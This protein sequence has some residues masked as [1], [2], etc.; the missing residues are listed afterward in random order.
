MAKNKLNLANS[1]VRKGKTL[2][3]FLIFTQILL[4]FTVI[5]PAQAAFPK[6]INFQGKLTKVSDGTNVATAAYAMEFKI[7]DALT[8]GTLLWTETYDQPSGNC[9]KPTITNGVFN[10]K[11]GTCNALTIDVTTGSLYVSVNFAPTGTSYD[12]EMS[13]RKQLVASAFAFNANNLVG[14]GRADLSY[15]PSNSTNPG[16]QINYA[17]GVSSANNALSVIASV[18]VTGPAVNISQAGSGV[19]L[20][21]A[22]AGSNARTINSTS[23]ALVL[24]TTTSGNITLNPQTG[25]VA[26]QGALS[27]TSGGATAM[28]VDAGGA[29]GLNLGT[30]SANALSIS[31]TGIA[32]TIQGTATFNEVATI[33]NGA[34]NDYLGFVAEGTNPSCSS[35]QYRIWAN[36]S[37]TKLKKCENGT[38]TDL[39]TTTGGSQTPWTTDIDAD[40]FSLLDFGPN[41]TSRATL[42]IASS[43]NGSGASSSVTATT[44]TGTS[45]SGNAVLNTGNASAGTAGN[46]VFDVGTSTASNG[47]ILIGT[48][49]RAQTV[50]IGNS[51]G[52]ATRLGQNG[53]TVQ[54]DGTNFDVDTNGTVTVA[55][56]QSY[57]GA[58]AVTLSSGASA[59]LTI[60]SASGRTTFATGDFLKTSVAGVSGAASG[61]IWYDSTANKYKINE[62]G[63]TKI[64]CNATDAGCG[65]GG[66]STLQTD[67][68]NDVDGS[69]VVIALTTA[70][71]S[72]IFQNP[73][74][75]GTDSAFTV[76]IDQL[77]TGAVDGL[78][79]SNAGTGS[80]LF[81]NATS[82]GALAALQKN[83]T[84]VFTVANNG[85]L[86]INGITTDVVKT[87]TGSTNSSDFSISGSTLTNITSQNDTITIND[88]SVPSSGNG[89]FA[90]STVVTTAAAGAGSHT[91]L[92]EDGQVIVVHGNSLATCSRW[93]GMTAT[94]TSV[95]CATGATNPGVGAISL[96]RPDGRYLLIH[97][98]TT[99]LSTLFDPWGV[100][101]NAAGPTANFC[102][103]AAEGTNAF[104]RDDGKY[105]VLCGG[106]TAW[107]VYD[108]TAN[109][110]VAGTAV[111]TAFG[112]GAFAIHRDDGTFLVFAGGN[113]T[114]HWIY[115]PYASAT[116]T[117][118]LNSI[119]SNA[120][121]ITTGAFA[122]RRQDGK[123]L[124]LGGAINTS[125]V[126]DPTP[127]NGTNSGAGSMTSQ[128]G[129]GFGPTA[130]LA[131]GAQAV[132]REDWKYTLIA[133][134]G[135][136]VTN[137]IDP[138]KSDSTQ[139]T[140]GANIT[141]AGAGVHMFFQPDGKF[142]VIRG[143][144]TT[145]TDTYDIGYI[146]G[147]A[148][149]GVALTAGAP[150]AGGSMTNGTHSY[151]VTFLTS[152][153][154]SGLGPVSNQINSASTNQTSALSA[155]PIGPAGT[156]GRRVYRTVAGDTGNYLLL[157]TISDN[158]TTTFSDTLAD[159]SLGTAAPT[160]T[161][162][163]YETEC[164]TAASLNAN[165]T[166]SWNTNSEGKFSFQ[167]R[168]GTA[169]ALSSTYKDIV[170]SG[171]PIRPT[172]GDT[173]IQIKV[174]FQRQIPLFADQEWGIRRGKGQT[175][176]RRINQDPSLFD[177]SVDN[178]NL[179]RKT[180]FDFGLGGGSGA[181]ATDPSGPLVV[182][183]TNNSDRNLSLTLPTGIGWG[184]TVNAT[185]PSLYNG[186]WST[187]P[188]AL[189][190]APVAAGSDLVMRRPD[191]RF[192]IV[193]SNAAANAQLYDP[194][195]QTVTA[196]SGGSNVPTAVIGTGA[197][198]FKRP[199]GKFFIVHGNASTTTNI[200][201]PVASTFAAGPATTAAV[202]IGAQ[203]IPLP[204]G[205]VLILHGN[206]TTASSIYDPVQN[207]MYS[208]PVTSAAVT[209]GSIVI[210]RPDGKWVVA[211]GQ[212]GTAPGT[213]PGALL[214]VSNTFDP[215]TMTFTATGSPAITGGPG[216]FAFQRS[217]GLWAI[218]RGGATITTCA[219]VTTT[220]IYNPFTNKVAAGPA[221]SAAAQMGAH[222]IP[223]P[224][225]TWLIVHGSATSATTT[226]IY[227]EKAG[228][229]T[230]E[231]GGSVGQFVA[232][233]ALVT[234]AGAGAV[235][236]QRPDGK[237][238][239][240]VGNATTTLN[241]YDAGWMTT[242]TY[243]S[244]EVTISDLDSSSTLVWKSN[245]GT[246]NISAEART[247][248]SQLGL[249]T[250]AWREIGVSGG[251]INPGA[252]ETWVQ[253][254]FNFKRTFPSYGGLQ[255]DVWYTGGGSASMYF[256]QRPVAV[257]TLYEYKVTKDIN[258]VNLQADGLSMFRVSSS[259]DIFTSSTGTVNT[260]GADLAER[261]TSSTL[262]EPGSVVAIDPENNHGVRLSSYQYQYDVLGIV[263][264]A[265]GFVA[266][267]YT[268]DSYPIA[269]IGRVPVKVTTENGPIRTGD[270]I[271]ASSLTGYAMK[272][273]QAGRVLGKVLESVDNAKL[274]DC[275]ASSMNIERQCATVMVFVNLIDYTGSSVEV[276]LSDFEQAQVS[277]VVE[278]NV[279]GLAVG[280][281]ISA[282]GSVQTVA[283]K[284]A[285]I[286]EFLQVLRQQKTASALNFSEV[287]TDRVSAAFEVITPAV[288]TQGLNV[289]NIT[290]IK[291]AITFQSDSIFFGRPYFNIDTA[292]FALVKKGQK[293]V[294]IVFDK[295]YVEQPVVSV[296]ISL[297]ESAE[298]TKDATPEKLVEIQTAEGALTDKLFASGIQF[299]VTRKNVHGFTIL[300]NKPL[301]E[302]LTFSWI[303]LAVK[304][305]RIFGADVPSINV[306]PTPHLG[307]VAGATDPGVA[308]RNASDGAT[309]NQNASESAPTELASPISDTPLPNEVS[310]I[311][312][313]NE[314]SQVQPPPPVPEFATP[315]PS[316]ETAS[317]N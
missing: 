30:S 251:L 197:L 124:V 287:F 151:K 165:S 57:A 101:A 236:F 131:D 246:Q 104:L 267:G 105:V 15:A 80:G 306:T 257:P 277:A 273:T 20:E 41:L 78:R 91:I 84:S 299:F 295:E 120:P 116:G 278:V 155:I 54:I 97:G 218:V 304:N 285:R 152:A 207:V 212:T 313:S 270:Y 314:A 49:S 288:Y 65:A 166:L 25:I 141:G 209:F 309:L 298:V 292:G 260:G 183:L 186:A 276:A 312:Q 290:S 4:A 51:T 64:L 185:N 150:T 252:S 148:L 125:S 8:S 280:E 300:L 31:R 275:P 89:T 297:D 76:K 202:G 81:I 68:G 286:L 35:G 19:G 180:Q 88:G 99:N 282:A 216:A 95:T 170:N 198:V 50:T 109:T 210:P 311:I 160:G 1:Y 230:T 144:N 264:T 279:E 93:D 22:G 82:T 153:G 149:P 110:F 176:Y 169:C 182:N 127:V 27:V 253:F 106:T 67:Y 174:F 32:T 75:S 85:G 100:T 103:T 23:G 231:A 133:G 227:I 208:G 184:T 255:T 196:Q 305:P 259:G 249:Q 154:E 111:G 172:S 220:D 241:Q 39:D 56:N 261:Y 237:I 188:V 191:G 5:T 59:G 242:G 234:G 245:F 177:V 195:V 226:S 98:N 247:A 215:Y 132:W 3:G 256:P 168:T 145:T 204:T 43:N 296:S 221:L 143:G 200:Y 163:Y 123:F 281:S 193:T 239:T 222:A 167:V 293:L 250:A 235:S 146:M 238:V 173:K 291:D 159:G 301:D 18:N 79:I 192:M 73:S 201:D 7:Y 271:T 17:P 224:D 263:S 61:D 128:S 203:M 60:D 228:A 69:D 10:I 33:G 315:P 199:D 130:A 206:S 37:N 117:M 258:L 137:V 181:T 142:R 94:M 139:F 219:A 171:D 240:L 102:T 156:I 119:T 114:T 45:G 53:G 136:T 24:K 205:R 302:D 189:A 194:I 96:K 28:T 86:T 175:R 52:G 2:L 178:G 21:L 140:A 161:S 214:T 70:D 158:V 11:L 211:L 87:T 36:S 126:Y 266:G 9:A 12:G 40:N 62:N 113:V 254:N 157:T 42:T 48:A 112:A 225:G 46:I 317:E 262:L 190:S 310:G 233:P 213:C 26:G 55:A 269:L 134:S 29:A 47:S 135:S 272:A 303:A 274:T 34:G 14:D 58:G 66:S 38:I 268:K 243:K 147:G 289:T 308:S 107:S 294:R 307:E 118:T 71:D 72:I 138:S 90:T 108:P 63:T 74:S 164:I 129:A 265:P 187:A 229:F 115:N 122:I 83:G 283:S 244:E 284:Q 232:G 13:P 121:T 6:Y 316:A 16:M 77:A 248:T 217:D 223:R 44:G 179:F 92:R 162:A